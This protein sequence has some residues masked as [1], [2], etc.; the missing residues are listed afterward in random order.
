GRGGVGADNPGAPQATSLPVTVTVTTNSPPTV[1]ITGPANGA[2]FIAPATTT[3]QATASDSDGSV[4][5][6]QFFDGNTSLGNR[7]S[8]PF[9]LSVN[10]AVA[11]HSPTAAD[12]DNLPSTTSTL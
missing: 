12:T 10:F 8:S 4:T 9:N 3:I 6:V 7:S 1:A 2:S 5:N 11:S